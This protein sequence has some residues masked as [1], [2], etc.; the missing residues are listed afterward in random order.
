[1]SDVDAQLDPDLII[2]EVRC[3]EYTGRDPNPNVPFSA[4]E[5][6]ADAAACRDAGASIVHFHARQPRTGAPA[7]DP[8]DYAEVI[9]AVRARTDVLLNPTLGAS[10]I[11]DPTVR[12][13]H[14]P[15]LG[16]DPA[17]RPDLAPVDLGS[18]NIDPYDPTTR[19]FRNEDLTYVTSV[20]GLRHE[21]DTI[22]A[23]EV[24]VQAVLWNVGSA[25]VLGAFR[26]M[27]VLPRTVLAQITLSDGWLSAHPGTARGLASMVEFLPADG[28]VHWSAS[29]FGGDLLTLLPTVLVLGGN[30]SIGLGDHHYAA[31]RGVDGSWPT[32]ADLVAEVARAAR[33]AGRE[34]ATPDEVRS[35]LQR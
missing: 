1:M 28:G 26:D 3:N 9:T 8:P 23:A 14:I 10:T 34:P 21:I 30:V 12:V 24:A 2:I 7:W 31:R 27:G 11:P 6:A 35:L 18:F 19:T 29:L 20:A 25:R 33:A 4:S 32:N 15:V 22:V 13:A 17:T 16:A 5:I